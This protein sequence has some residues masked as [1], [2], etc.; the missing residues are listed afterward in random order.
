M[1]QSTNDSQA[2]ERSITV[3]VAQNYGSEAIYPA[4]KPAELFAKL[5][6]TRTLTRASIG[7]IK[8]LGFDVKVQ[9]EV[10]EL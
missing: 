3:R 2:S 5:A 4:D 10:P 1:Q 7:V 9:A 6:G 8:Q